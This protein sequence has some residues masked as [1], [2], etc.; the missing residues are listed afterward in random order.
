MAKL[1]NAER[2]VVDIAKLR[3]YSLNPTH[4]VGKHKA[5]VFRSALGLTVD[6]GHGCASA[7]CKQHLIG[8]PSSARRHLS[9]KNTCSI[10]PSRLKDAKPR[11][12]LLGLLNTI[13][14]F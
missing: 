6:D 11:S 2:A 9:G 10:L 4:D 3:D 7:C 14:T 13:P 5:R 1:P 12:V 8:K